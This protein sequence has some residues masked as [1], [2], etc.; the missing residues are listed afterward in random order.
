MFRKYTFN[1][2]EVTLALLVISVGV[3]SIMGLIPIGMKAHRDAMHNNR[4]ADVADEMAHMIAWYMQRSWNTYATTLPTEPVD[5]GNASDNGPAAGATLDINDGSTKWT[6]VSGVT[7]EDQLYCYDDNS[8][9]FDF[10]SQMEAS[11]FRIIR[12][13]EVVLDDNTG[14][15]RNVTDMDAV[16]RMWKS[17]V[18]S[19]SQ[20]SGTF[21]FRQVSYSKAIQLNVEVSWPG[22]VKYGD[23]EKEIFSIEV[24][25]Q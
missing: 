3:V 11:L 15:T 21:D 20:E 5:I 7:G 18:V 23:R 25:R 24:M 8:N 19:W 13:R 1:L 22:S 9:G 12:S 2:I 10:S 6:L 16:I 17:P 14:K 4:A